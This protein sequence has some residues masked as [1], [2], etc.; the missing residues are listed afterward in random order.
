MTD[1]E[2]YDLNEIERFGDPW[3]GLVKGGVI[4]LPNSGTKALAGETPVS[5]DCFLVQVPG[6]P[7]VTTSAEDAA[8][9][10]TWTNYGLL[11][12]SQH[13]L[14]GV[15][16]NELSWLYIAPDETV[17][18]V[19][20]AN[21]SGD[22]T[23]TRFG[24]L[25]EDP[26]AV[27][28]TI[29]LSGVDTGY[30]TRCLDLTA[31]GNKA[32]IGSAVES[33]YYT[34]SRA[35]A[36]IL[37]GV[38][39]I[40]ISGTPPAASATFATLADETACRGT[41]S[42]TR[43]VAMDR[44]T[45][46]AAPHPTSGLPWPDTTTYERVDWSYT[47]ATDTGDTN[48]APTLPAGKY[49]TYNNGSGG[50]Y[51]TDSWVVAVANPVDLINGTAANGGTATY[52]GTKAK[53]GVVIGA[54]FAGG[55]TAQLVTVDMSLTDSNS[56][57]AITREGALAIKIGATAIETLPF[58][59]SYGGGVYTLNLGDIF[60]SASAAALMSGFAVLDIFADDTHV[61]LAGP[62]T[63]ETI[64]GLNS[65]GELSS[66][67]YSGPWLTRFIPVR[68]S[69]NAYGFLYIRGAGWTLT[70]WNENT[71]LLSQRHYARSVFGG[72]RKELTVPTRS[73]SGSF[74]QPRQRLGFA[75][76]HPV[77][78]VLELQDNEVVFK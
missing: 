22:L 38:F 25:G 78:Y 43:Q 65:S 77:T 59:S 15:A 10:M 13:I 5:G 49:Y 30:F 21:G 39:L 75:T 61:L 24:L 55:T 48:P 23:F 70:P 28:Q 69:N 64:E 58:E 12:G 36:N 57:L 72:A 8:E 42:N 18:R 37:G 76:A 74:Y 29:S 73:I 44:F 2:T 40:E 63:N 31:T 26:A 27:A 16:L 20:Y 62:S 54:T 3:H 53:T 52:S 14:Y 66:G 67:S 32:L 56:G 19:Q 34:P 35:A 41:A 7:A 33:V 4:E 1:G 9:G 51:L 68:Y 60:S 45:T 50:V 71:G 17:W 47:Y 11:Y 46:V 6:Q